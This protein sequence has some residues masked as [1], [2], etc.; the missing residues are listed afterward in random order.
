MVF[1]C[2]CPI[3]SLCTPGDDDSYFE[4]RWTRYQAVR[5]VEDTIRLAPGS[6]GRSSV[7]PSRIRGQTRGCGGSSWVDLA[8]LSTAISK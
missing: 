4:D 8:D 2:Q 3:I 1:G 6:L 7:Y 5:G